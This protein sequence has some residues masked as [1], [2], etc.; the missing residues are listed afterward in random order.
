[1]TDGTGR[2]RKQTRRSRPAGPRAVDRRSSAATRPAEPPDQ[3]EI[4]RRRAA[5]SSGLIRRQLGQPTARVSGDRPVGP[6]HGAAAALDQVRQVSRGRRLRRCP[7]LV[8]F[9]QGEGFDQAGNRTAAENAA[10]ERSGD[11][12]PVASAARRS[13][14][15]AL[16]PTWPIAV[17]LIAS[18]PSCYWCP[19][20]DRDLVLF[21]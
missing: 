21:G 15:A 4:C 19:A 18:G 17:T 20:G 7:Q 10:A 8:A 14:R 2:G 16:V 9:G 6:D 11:D 13:A 5:W 12:D 3:L 1:M